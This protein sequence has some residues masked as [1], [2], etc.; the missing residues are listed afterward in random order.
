MADALVFG[1]PNALASKLADRLSDILRVPVRY[2]GSRE[3]DNRPG[4]AICTSVEAFIAGAP[5]MVFA[6]RVAPGPAAPAGER[7]AVL[8]ALA[9]AAA[10][11]RYVRIISSKQ[12]A[13]RWADGLAAS[14]LRT[15]RPLRKL[16]ISGE[17]GSGKSTLAAKLAPALA[18][19]LVSV[20][21]LFWGDEE[22][23]N[24]GSDARRQQVDSVLARD[25]WLTEGVYRSV[26]ARL[27]AQADATVHVDLP[28]G[29][30]KRQRDARGRPKRPLRERLIV[31]TLRKT[32]PVHEHL[33]RRDLA[34]LAHASAV[35]IVCS[36]AE[37]E[38]VT[39]GLLRG[40]ELARQESNSSGA[41]A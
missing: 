35:F 24:G 14:D 39:E 20:D 31:A 36:E 4:V 13:G 33:L 8:R 1:A 41:P 15:P 40:A 18:I 34:R 32:N 19:P 21:D 27:S 9:E 6:D 28:P 26:A 23:R 22:T 11:G 10:R 30:A 25:S 5:I 16:N 17:S 12:E 37:R 29:Q 7:I 2:Q 3:E 38:A